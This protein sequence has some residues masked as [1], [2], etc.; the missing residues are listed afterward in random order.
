MTTAGRAAWR[1]AS[2]RLGPSRGFGCAPTNDGLTMIVA[3]WPYA[4]AKAYKADVEANFTSTL[5][6]I[7]SMASRLQNAR[8]EAPFLGGS[9]PGYFR[10]PFGPGWVL[11]GD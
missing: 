9:V 7:P 4:D 2:R 3:S 5:R 11:I 1:R 10:R 8:R 6:L